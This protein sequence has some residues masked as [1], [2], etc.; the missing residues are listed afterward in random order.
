MKRLVL[1]N[2][3]LKSTFLAELAK[4]EGEALLCYIILYPS[5]ELKL[6]K[7]TA[8]AAALGLPLVVR[9]ASYSPP[10]QEV[11]I[12]MLYLMLFV[13]PMAKRRQ[14]K[15]IYHGLSRDDDLRIVPVMDTFTK[16]LGDLISLAQPLYASDST[17]LGN[18]EV[19]T[20]LRRLCRQ[21]VIR[22]GNEYCI[23]WEL[24]HSCSQSTTIHCGQCSDC[25]RRQDAFKREGHD[26]PT[27]YQERNASE[28][29]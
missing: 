18:I 1:F 12:R 28:R 19:E 15:C 27:V 6:K 23:P 21:H 22:L 10:L 14:C 17:W 26:D 20:P 24:T 8:L 2:G 5:D 16:Q 9:Q 25:R 29:S 11:L 13:L 4:K 7:V 3:G